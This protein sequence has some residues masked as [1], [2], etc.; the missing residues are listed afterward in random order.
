MYW[1]IAVTAPVTKASDENGI[2]AVRF[3]MPSKWTM[4]TLPAPADDRVALV[5]VPVRHVV[6]SGLM[7][8]K[9]P[10]SIDAAQKA[11]NQFVASHGLSPAGE[12][13][14]AGYSARS[15][16]DTQKVES[17]FGGSA[18]KLNTGR[19]LGRLAQTRGRTGSKFLASMGSEPSS[20]VHSQKTGMA[21]TG[22]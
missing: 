2:Y 3:M 7:S 16:P 22:L 15:V 21:S 6:V 1:K 9:Q 8:A 10:A 4:D 13:T 14:L 12:F 17:T 19:F 20:E 11:I 18:A 5:Q